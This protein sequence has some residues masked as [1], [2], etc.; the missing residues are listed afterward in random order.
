[1]LKTRQDSWTKEEDIL[2]AEIVLTHIR[3]GGTQLQAFEEVGKQLSRTSS[4]CG[5]RWN[6]N[7]RKM[8][9]TE[10]ELAKQQRKMG[11][12]DTDS[13]N[14]S[15]MK[16]LSTPKQNDEPLLEFDRL[17][18]QLRVLYEISYTSKN[19]KQDNLIIKN[20]SDQVEMLKNNNAK[21][22]EEKNRLEKEYKALKELLE[23]ANQILKDKSTGK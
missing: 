13:N 16:G 6:A 14:L 22:S 19:S 21:L 17:I 2:L 23:S 11:A 9:R 12:G 3:E 10:I 5:F 8:Y 4:A 15:Y 20:L 7:V 1:M 18:E